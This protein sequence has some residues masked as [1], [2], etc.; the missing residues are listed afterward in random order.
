M[1]ALILRLKKELQGLYCERECA[2]E[3]DDFASR[4]DQLKAVNRAISRLRAAIEE[5]EDATSLVV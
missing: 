4:Q 3:S 5:A 1:N 2:Q